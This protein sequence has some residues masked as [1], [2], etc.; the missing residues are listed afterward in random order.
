[1]CV[2][3]AVL[4]FVRLLYDDCALRSVKQAKTFNGNKLLGTIAAI[5]GIQHA[6]SVVFH[7]GSE[8]ITSLALRIFQQR[9]VTGH[10]SAETVCLP[11]SLIVYVLLLI[12]VGGACH[13]AVDIMPAAKPRWALSET[14]SLG[15]RNAFLEEAVL[16]PK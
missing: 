1:V 7:C 2:T 5:T 8:A 11:T 4:G 12:A 3:Q 6:C 14:S 16:R 10:G 9:A 13:F 15:C